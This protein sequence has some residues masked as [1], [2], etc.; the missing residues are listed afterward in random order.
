MRTPKH[1]QYSVN[2][3]PICDSLLNLIR[4]QRSA[5]LSV[6]EMAPKSPSLCVNRTPIRC[7]FH[8]GAKATR[9]SVD[10]ALTSAKGLLEMTLSLTYQNEDWPQV[11]SPLLSDAQRVLTASLNT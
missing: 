2:S 5:A 6:T 10:I 8:A 1:I 4:D 3:Y 7:G 9:Y 11:S